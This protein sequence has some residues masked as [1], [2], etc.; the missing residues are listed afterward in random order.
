MYIFSPMKFRNFG[1]LYHKKLWNT[2]V[3][4]KKIL[5][6]LIRHQERGCL[7]LLCSSSCATSLL[8]VQNYLQAI[9]LPEY[10]RNITMHLE[11]LSYRKQMLRTSLTWPAPSTILIVEL[12]F[13]ILLTGLGWN[14]IGNKIL[15]SLLGLCA[16]VILVGLVQ[17]FSIIVSRNR[18]DGH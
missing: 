7:A 15:C 16:V 2:V 17:Y 9:C 18:L 13:G 3:P 4:F 6:F 10:S 8:Q 11:F 5:T 14:I 1:F 12:V